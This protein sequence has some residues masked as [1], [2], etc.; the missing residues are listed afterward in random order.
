MGPKYH[1]DYYIQGGNLYFLVCP[2]AHDISTPSFLTNTKTSAKAEKT[3]F[4]V[5]SY[6]FVRESKHWEEVLVYPEGEP[7]KGQDVK[8]PFVLEEEPEDFAQFLWVFYNKYV[9]S[10]KIQRK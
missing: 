2:I 4:R 7:R 9:F 1:K 5:H 8:N 10:L 6:F 3:L